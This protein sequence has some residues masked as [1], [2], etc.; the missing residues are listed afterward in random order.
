M[1]RKKISRLMPGPEDR[2]FD[3][4]RT[5]GPAY[6]PAAG[7]RGRCRVILLPTAFRLSEPDQA[8]PKNFIKCEMAHTFF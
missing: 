8:Q 4:F 5:F 6:E 1:L 3:P 7:A 2:L